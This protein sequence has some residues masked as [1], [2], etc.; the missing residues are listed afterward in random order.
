M[1][2][3]FDF[4]AQNLKESGIVVF[5]FLNVLFYGLLGA[6]S[7]NK[8]GEKEFQISVVGVL[9][10]RFPNETIRKAEDEQSVYINE[11]EYSLFNLYKFYLTAS[12]NE[13]KLIFRHFEKALR[14]TEVHSKT[15][16]SWE[17][18]K[19]ILMSQIVRQTYAKENRIFQGRTFGNSLVVAYVLNYKEG[20]RYVLEEDRSSWKV[21]EEEMFQNAIVNLDR[22]SQ[23]AK[24][25][26]S[27]SESLRSI[28]IILTMRPEFF[29]QR[30]KNGL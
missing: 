27:S 28:R 29:C 7:K 21:S 22:I 24:I 1:N 15:S 18:A 16:L 12:E 26:E 4:S 6:E 13:E 11:I 3:I 23:N 10:K 9:K 14:M 17:K 19:T 2:R 5:L 25:V 30:F 20:H 8:L